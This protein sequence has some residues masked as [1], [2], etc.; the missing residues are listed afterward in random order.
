LLPILAGILFAAYFA[1]TKYIYSHDTEQFLGI[2][3]VTRVTEALIALV[4]IG[5]FLRVPPLTKGRLGGVS[6]HKAS[7]STPSNSPL[8]RGRAG[9]LFICN[10][11]LAAGAFLLQTYAISIGSV[12]V[13]NA[14]QGVQY[15]FVLVLAVIVS[16]FFPKLFRE[17]VQ[18]GALVQKLAG[19]ILVSFGVA[20]LV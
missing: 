9:L 18:Q 4:G 10:K 8:V 15:A 14:L 1:V 17:E 5:I 3:I 11:T 2:F 7:R 20:L 16:L 19:I 12:S 6:D 13:V